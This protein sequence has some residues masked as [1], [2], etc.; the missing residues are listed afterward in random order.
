VS[1]YN[2]VVAADSSASLAPTV[3]AR[4]ATEMADPTSD[5]GASLSGTFAPTAR[6]PVVV[7]DDFRASADGAL[8]GAVPTVGP[9]WRTTGA[10][11]PVVD[12]GA[13]T[14]SGTGYAYMKPTVSTEGIWSDVSFVIGSSADDKAMTMAFCLTDDAGMLDNLAAHLNWGPRSFSLKVR[15]DGEITFPDLIRG[16]WEKDIPAGT[17]ARVGLIVRG[18]TATVLGPNGEIRSVTDPRI[19]SLNGGTVF[20]EPRAVASSTAH[21]RSIIATGR[22]DE[23]KASGYA[24]SADLAGGGTSQDNYGRLLGSRETMA[25]VAAGVD[26]SNGMPTV[27]FG[28]ATIRT[29]LE[30]DAAIGASSLSTK[31]PIPPG[32]SLRID[33]GD[34]VETITSGSLSTGTGRPYSTPLGASTT[35]AHTSG[36]VVVAT[37][38]STAQK[39]MYLNPS[40][41]Y[42]Y[43]PN[44]PVLVAPGNKLYLGS[45]LTTYVEVS[46]GNVRTSTPLRVQVGATI[47][48]GSGAPTAT[49]A[50]G[51]IYFRTDTP[52]VSN[53]RVYICTSGTS[54]TG[55]V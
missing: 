22:T 3:R 5:V 29:T 20:W 2:R 40:N 50:T 18:A 32:S 53:Q 37:T 36:A 8:A 33:S 6:I 17:F 42:F 44:V 39:S 25:Q 16:A 49:G 28:A 10:V 48:S 47:S 7:Y 15:Q 34:S 26:P 14:S 11:P 51:D 52:A 4:L 12:A 1:T 46:A 9:T 21:I 19:A 35:I 31:H 38:T 27:Y 43:L 41:G 24:T 13:V 30:A 45:A 23:G 54:W 55:I